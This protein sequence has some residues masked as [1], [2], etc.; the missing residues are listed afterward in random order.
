[1]GQKNKNIFV[2]AITIAI[3]LPLMML[4]NPVAAQKKTP[5]PP[6]INIPDSLQNK[7]SVPDKSLPSLN[8]KEYTI[9]GRERLRVLPSQRQ[10]IGLADI[11]TRE[12]NCRSGE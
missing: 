5:P 1:M 2:S 9:L 6:K 12:K 8:L 7:Q 4:V 11:T 3:A 10:A